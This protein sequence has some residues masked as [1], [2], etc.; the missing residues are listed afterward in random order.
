MSIVFTIVAIGICGV[1]GGVSGW[2]IVTSVGLDGVT[3]ALA[4]A[5]VAMVVSSAAWVAGT[6]LWRV[7]AE[8]R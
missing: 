6:S 3:G 1:V 8:H 7:M 4:A 5:F 2:A